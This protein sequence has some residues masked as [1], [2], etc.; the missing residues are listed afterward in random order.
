MTDADL[1][2]AVDVTDGHTATF[3]RE[4]VRRAVLLESERDRD[5]PVQVSGESLAEAARQFAKDRADLAESKLRGPE[6]PDGGPSMAM[7]PAAK[8]MAMGAQ[9]VA[10]YGRTWHPGMEEPPAPYVT[11]DK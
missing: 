6:E 7:G 3:I 10:T 9:R 5:V 1:A 2:E 4:V 8:W 11:G